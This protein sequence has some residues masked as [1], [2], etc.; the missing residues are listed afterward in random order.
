MIRKKNICLYISLL[1]STLFVST[2]ATAVYANNQW[3]VSY[4][5]GKYS[6]TRLAQNLLFESEIENSTVHVVSLGKQLSVIKKKI[7]VELEGQIGFHEGLQDHQEFNGSFTLRYLDF[8]WDHIVDTSF[9][10]GNG[11]SYATADPY[12]EIDN[13]ENGHT[14]QILYYILAEWAF[15]IHPQWEIFWR[16]HHRSGIYGLMADRDAGS[17][18]IG[19]GLR[20]RY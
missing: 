13:A 16:I 9:A 18:F 10:F 3:F 5:I 8:P 6:D 19:I 2:G 17:N 15:N 4:Y 1:L 20:F 11:I 14:S 12:L 7:A